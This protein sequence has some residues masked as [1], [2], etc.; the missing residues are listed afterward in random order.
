MFR[1]EG[2]IVRKRKEVPPAV[3]PAVSNVITDVDAIVTESP[4][5][6]ADIKTVRK[7]RAAKF[8]EL[9]QGGA[10][11]V[12]AARQVGSLPA[13]LSKDPDVKALVATLLEQFTF[14]AEQR[15]KMARAKANEIMLTGDPRDA[16][17]ALKIVAADPEVGIAQQAP[18]IAQ[19]FLSTELTNFMESQEIPAEWNTLPSGPVIEVKKENDE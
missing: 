4:E 12:D 6:H 9:V 2:K 15:K 10:T 7:I 13:T 19:Q 14:P 5:T 11:A 1:G 8:V 17:N 18:L 3:L 16:I